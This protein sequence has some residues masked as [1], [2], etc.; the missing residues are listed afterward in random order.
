MDEDDQQHDHDQ[1]PFDGFDE[2]DAQDAFTAP[3]FS[4]IPPLFYSEET[5]EPFSTCI[6][7]GTSLDEDS[8]YLIQKNSNGRETVFEFAI[9]TSC[10]AKLH[11]SYSEKSRETIVN[12]F[13]DRTDPEQRARE[14]LAEHPDGDLDTWLGHCITCGEK[15]QPGK[16]FATAALCGGSDLV[17]AHAPFLICEKC[18]HEVNESLSPETRG[19]IDR[20]IGDN[21]DLPPTYA[22]SPDHPVTILA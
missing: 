9:C 13:A 18:E 5:G 8:E 14:L 12:F 2:E 22:P 7:C 6:D 4:P 21:F 11:A 3:A 1:T 10:A 16:G 20:F 17:F 19:E 15:P